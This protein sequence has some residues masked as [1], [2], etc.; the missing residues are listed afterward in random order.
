L[1]D[2]EQSITVAASDLSI[3][4]VNR[5]LNDYKVASKFSCRV[6]VSAQDICIQLIET[7]LDELMPTMDNL[8]WIDSTTTDRHRMLENLCS[9]VRAVDSCI[10]APKAYYCFKGK[11][12]SPAPAGCGIFDLD[13]VSQWIEPQRPFSEG[14]SDLEYASLAQL[15]KKEKDM[16]YH[17]S[18]ATL[19]W[20]PS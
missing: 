1:N 12:F 6:R 15:V 3:S 14:P 10:P 8:Y 2:F 5:T 16:L 17:V 13:K 11:Q 18:T 7:L 4:L 19:R 20:K 9:V